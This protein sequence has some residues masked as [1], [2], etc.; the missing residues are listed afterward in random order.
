MALETDIKR[1]PKSEWGGGLWQ[2][3]PEEYHF[4]TGEFLCLLK[5]SI[6]GSWNSYIRI[7]KSFRFDVD[8][9]RCHGGVSWNE[10]HLPWQEDDD[11]DYWYIGWDYAHAHDYSPEMFAKSDHKDFYLTH[12]H[13]YTL[14]E[15]CLELID[16]VS[17]LRTI[18]KD[19]LEK[20]A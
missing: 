10:E 9:I 4:E 13:Y 11:K 1:I 12:T 14:S 5:R 17:Q 16:V 15:C 20:E 3:E 18:W 8:K 6:M 2:E 7:P 19:D